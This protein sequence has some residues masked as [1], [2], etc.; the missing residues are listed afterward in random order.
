MIKT[1]SG[2]RKA[3]LFLILT[4]LIWG[5]TFT[6]TKSGLDQASPLILTGIRF[7]IACLIFS[8][9]FRKHLKFITKQTAA[10][11]I[12]LGLLMF[13]TYATQ[14]M[15]LEYTSAGRSGFITYSFALFTPPL[16]LLIL[17]RRPALKNLIGLV[18]ILAGLFFIMRPEAGSFNR[19]D[20]LT[21][22]CAFGLAFYVICIDMMTRRSDTFILTAI[23]FLT[24]AILSFLFSP[25]VEE[26]R[27]TI[28]GELILSV[29]YLGILGSAVGLALMIRY[30]K[31]LSPT[32]AVIMYS[33]EPLFSVF[34]AM[35]FL[36][37]K[38]SPGECGGCGLILAGVFLS[39][40][41]TGTHAGET[42]TK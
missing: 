20:I 38:L 11:G 7:S 24:T 40:M 1:L 8:L 28:S 31:E 5:G 25:L 41:K 6:V 4:T 36:S 33:L 34:I 9:L 16:Q 35:I 26:P 18:I 19:G 23:Q 13:I 37:E 32:K 42:V 22:I 29:L 14:T 30:Q 27:F 15:G 39:E 21:L 12:V 10:D 2:A 17:K 3:E